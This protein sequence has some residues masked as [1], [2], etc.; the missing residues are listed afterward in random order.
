MARLLEEQG[1]Y[2]SRQ[3]TRDSWDYTRNIVQARASGY[4][5]PQNRTPSLYA[6]QGTVVRQGSE[7]PGGTDSSITKNVYSA[8]GAPIGCCATVVASGTE[9]FDNQNALIKKAQ[10]CICKNE[11]DKYWLYNGYAIDMSGTLVKGG[12]TCPIPNLVNTA[13]TTQ[14]EQCASCKMFY[15]PNPAQPSLCPACPVPYP[16][17]RFYPP[18]PIDWELRRYGDGTRIP[19]DC[20]PDPTLGDITITGLVYGQGPWI[21]NWT[22]TNTQTIGAA[23]F[24]T[25]MTPYAATITVNSLTQVTIADFTAGVRKN[26]LFT[27][28]ITASN[29]C[30]SVSRSATFYVR[31]S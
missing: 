12:W 6:I 23:V 2:R 18:P 5:F 4:V 30:G 16:N 15:F 26:G 28:T 31:E 19:Q 3:Q 8:D 9:T 11:G 29:K 24:D 20:G 17:N 10:S 22:Q 25:T 21:A 13:K 7:V 1:R 27:L 14:A